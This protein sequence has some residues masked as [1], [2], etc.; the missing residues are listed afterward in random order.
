MNS[1]N[2]SRVGEVSLKRR[3]FS[4]PTLISFGIAAAF[5]AFLVA[6]FDLDWGATWDNI[7]TMNP[8]LYVAGFTLYYLSFGIRGLRWRILARNAAAHV[9]P[10]PKLPSVFEFAKLIILGWFVSSIA[11]LRMGDAYRAYAF[12]QDSGG[13]FS[14]SLGT[15]LAERAVDIATVF[16]LLLIGAIAFF[17]STGSIESIYVLVAASVLALVMAGLLVLMRVSGRRLARFL[18]WGL[19]KAYDGFHEGTLGSFKQLPMVF[20]L[21]LIS[22]FLEVARLYFVVQA[23]GL[24][25]G[26]PL[27]LVVTLGNALLTTV[28]TPG[29]VG[30]V[31][32]GITGL[33]VL[34]LARSDAVSVV[35][36]DRSIT[37]ISV[38][39]FGGLVFVLRQVSLARRYRRESVLAGSD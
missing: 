5:I 16:A 11:P 38:I 36:V 32:P 7:R 30:A 26:L 39:L 9:S 13:R 19:E 23:L 25:V 34:S 17:V 35:L 33:L 4:L 10:Y 27:V 18:P 8:W 21:G 14:W 29:G 12:A 1:Q 6:R 15:V 3:V 31:E 24:D 37:Y 22:W 20:A 28:P 2:N